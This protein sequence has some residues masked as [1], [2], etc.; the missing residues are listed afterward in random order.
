MKKGR[1]KIYS[2]TLP[3]DEE[4]SSYKHDRKVDSHSSLEIKRFEECCGV[5][6]QQEEEGGEV[7]GQ[8]LIGDSP[9]K[10]N[11]H[12]EPRG[13]HHLLLMDSAPFK[14]PAL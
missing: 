3:P 14:T 6:D 7:G 13:C 12:L 11:L 1:F 8:Q 5:C 2:S 4:V 10:Y 9:L